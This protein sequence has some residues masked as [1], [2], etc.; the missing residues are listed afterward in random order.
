MPVLL[1]ALGLA[2]SSTTTVSGEAIRPPAP[3]VPGERWALLVAVD[4]YPDE[5]VLSS[6]GSVAASNG[7][8]D[9][10]VQRYGFTRSHIIEL[11]DR[12]ATST[13]ISGELQRL[14]STMKRADSLFIVLSL[15]SVELP[16]ESTV[17]LVPRGVKAD[18]P[19]ALISVPQI[20][21][22]FIDLPARNLLAVFG[23]CASRWEFALREAQE[24]YSKQDSLSNKKPP[25][26]AGRREFLSTCAGGSMGVRDSQ[27]ARV[28]EW[29]QKTPSP[30][31]WRRGLELQQALSSRFW[32]VEATVYGPAPGY[33]FVVGS[34]RS[35]DLL[36][37][38]DK[39][40]SPEERGEA[41]ERLAR[42]HVASNAQPTPGTLVPTLSGIAQSTEE[43]VPLRQRAALALGQIRTPE[44]ADALVHL[45]SDAS[46]ELSLT[47][48]RAIEAFP[49]DLAI[50]SLELALA[51]GRPEVQ[52]SAL[53]ALVSL[54]ARQ[55]LPKI[56]AV[57]QD[58][59]DSEVRLAC[60]DALQSL[61]VEGSGAEPTLVALT[62]DESSPEVS[63]AA[64]QLLTKIGMETNPALFRE[65]LEGAAT[66]FVRRAAAYALGR[67]TP[68][69]PES[70]AALVRALEGGKTDVREAAAHS[71]G[72][73]LWPSD[74][75]SSGSFPE[76]REALLRAMRDPEPTV[77]IA[78]I[79]ALGSS[80]EPDAIRP[81]QRVLESGSA[82][83]RAAAALA[84]G[85]L[86]A[87]EAFPALVET[88]TLNESETV[89][90]SAEMALT[91]LL[92]ATKFKGVHPNIE[93]APP[94]VQAAALRWLARSRDP[95]WMD[96]FA[97]AL[98]S[99]NE[100]LRGAALEGLASIGS[101]DVAHLLAAEAARSKGARRTQIVKALAGIGSPA[102]M[103][104]LLQLSRSPDAP[105]VVIEALG[106]FDS[107]E[108]IAR[109]MELTDS[110]DSRQ[111]LAA[112][113]AVQRQAFSLHQRGDTSRA[114]HMGER[115]LEIRQSLLGKDHPEL[116]ADFDNLGVM[117]L[118][119]GQLELSR[120]RLLKSLDLRRG[121]ERP[122]PAVASTHDNLGVI[123]LRRARYQEAL[124]WYFQ[125]L[126]IREYSLGKNSEE[127]AST[128]RSIA[129]VYEKSGDPKQAEI[130]R[131]RA[132]AQRSP[133]TA[134]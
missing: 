134:D 71:L 73:L 26:P 17:F 64:I 60:L 126:D 99:E 30:G 125:A 18:S 37:A 22:S 86:G 44:S 53:R 47:A 65:R 133:A 42:L 97:S 2:A 85:R 106:T 104:S 91:S 9:V 118:A 63:A 57:L 83:E 55:S 32:S 19:W 87:V 124:D 101:D 103:K 39:Q 14:S 29:L 8:R 96:A 51:A 24:G 56:A 58:S 110:K 28:L 81:L 3:A 129:D 123:A 54:R 67:L 31:E 13:R 79:G 27:A 36:V 113:G 70:V 105:T 50:R 88:A 1:M 98:E 77:R 25:R 61:G 40:R 59:A 131:Q 46:V 128:L 90:H 72:K 115:A 130:Y 93:G 94:E 12:D 75:R 108:A 119:A 41:I 23:G 66:T 95:A 52:R 4:E 120:V 48:V 76:A 43:P 21:S 121:S 100:I 127:V 102:A 15:A 132:G 34:G 10:L 16:K 74:Q 5:Q 107:E 7:I 117:S 116:A 11:Y 111:R 78:A 122:D 49:A 84:L 45:T 69:E 92:E 68:A 89:R 80:S 33:G 112:A 6:K 109:A 20:V 82:D 38:T 35:D 62:K 114:I